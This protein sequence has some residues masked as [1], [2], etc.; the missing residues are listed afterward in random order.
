MLLHSNTVAALFDKN[1]FIIAL[2]NGISATAFDYSI[3]K[4]YQD[5]VSALTSYDLQKR[6]V[7]DVPHLAAAA[8]A[9]PICAECKKLFAQV[10]S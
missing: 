7:D 6:S 1:I 9:R 3:N 8:P 2:L 5:V 10:I 4:I